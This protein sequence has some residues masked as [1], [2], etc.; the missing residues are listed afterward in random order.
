MSPFWD[1]AS[2]K[3]TFGAL[4]MAQGGDVLTLAADFYRVGRNRGI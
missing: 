3:G 2:E 4:P 1:G